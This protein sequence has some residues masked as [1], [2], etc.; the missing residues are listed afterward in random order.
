MQGLY[1]MIHR[2]SLYLLCLL[3]LAGC[4]SAQ[5]GKDRMESILGTGSVSLG[6]L[7]LYEVIK[8]DLEK[9]R[10]MQARERA[11]AM[12]E[13]HKDYEKVRKLLQDKIEPARQRLFSHY[14]NLAMKAE[15]GSRWHEA[16]Q[17]YEQAKEL[18]LEPEKMEKKRQQM[19]LKLRQLRLDT[20]LKQRRAEDEF[21]L[22]RMRVYEPP[23]GVSPTDDVFLRKREEQ[24]EELE[25]RA[26]TAYRNASRY[27]RKGIPEVAYVEIESYL[28][29]QPD[30]DR[31]KKLM[32]EIRQ[33]MPRSLSVSGTK[34]KS[35]AATGKRKT[36]KVTLQQIRE[37][38]KQE[39]WLQ[40]R[41][42]ALVYR[43]EGGREADALLERIQTAI[44]KEAAEE[45]S[46]GGNFFRQERLDEAVAH[47][48]QA[49]ELM[50]DEAEYVE[51]LR[52]A[53]QLQERLQL[54]RQNGASATSTGQ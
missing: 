7:S 12:K 27:L 44:Q 26:S 4:Q 1:S 16:V 25:D 15:Q 19:E 23:A 31:G 24:E 29:L 18:S 36:V 49:V 50:P 48:Q 34:S 38:M 47:W 9:G 51:A 32:D 11:L 2:C 41:K 17:A 6:L 52:R 30:S 43:R 46:R 37:S 14:L 39:K 45:F 3:V 22:R 20:L 35:K 10:I 40:A 42:Q 21:L 28:R 8:R 53:R 54:L 33:A 13:S 5:V